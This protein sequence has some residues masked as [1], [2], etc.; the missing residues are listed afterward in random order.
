M[1]DKKN[2]HAF[3][4]FENNGMKSSEKKE[5]NSFAKILENKFVWTSK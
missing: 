3:E 2:V 1:W 5:K 4:C